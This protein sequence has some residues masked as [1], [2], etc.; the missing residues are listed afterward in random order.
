MLKFNKKYCN[1]RL[2]KNITL[3]AGRAHEILSAD[4]QLRVTGKKII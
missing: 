1:I 4:L 2:S 3:Q